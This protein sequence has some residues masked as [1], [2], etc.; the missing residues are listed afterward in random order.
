MARVTLE[1]SAKDYHK[2]SEYLKEHEND[3]ARGKDNFGELKPL[4]IS[5]FEENPTL[6]TFGVI[7][8]GE[9]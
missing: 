4:F 5:I 6:T 7:N 9:Y 1:L 8:R 2:L 3:I